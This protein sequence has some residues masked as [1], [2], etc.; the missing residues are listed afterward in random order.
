MKC[1]G[2]F[3]VVVP[4]VGVP[5]SP[6]Q[7]AK[8]YRFGGVSCDGVSMAYGRLEAVSATD[9]QRILNPSDFLADQQL[10][11]RVSR[12]QAGNRG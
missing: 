11:L 4:K 9:P 8:P 3:L 1:N 5:E 6:D 12:E 7:Q 2:N 10:G